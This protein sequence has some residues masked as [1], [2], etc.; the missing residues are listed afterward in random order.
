MFLSNQHIKFIIKLIIKF[1][2]DEIAQ[3]KSGS[4]ITLRKLIELPKADCDKILCDVSFPNVQLY[5]QF[6]FL[7]YEP[8]MLLGDKKFIQTK[9]FINAFSFPV[10]FLKIKRVSQRKI[11]R[12]TRAGPAKV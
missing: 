8:K 5:K 9:E 12:L 10:F 3:K 6:Q 11:Q 1:I 7:N 2:I 4:K